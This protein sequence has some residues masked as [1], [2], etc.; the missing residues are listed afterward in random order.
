MSLL[1]ELDQQ[2]KA[3]ESELQQDESEVET[4]DH[5]ELEPIPPLPPE[6]R[7]PPG[8]L[9]AATRRKEQ[10]LSKKQVEC[11]ICSQVFEGKDAF[12][13]HTRTLKHRQ[14][15]ILKAGAFYEAANHQANFCR[16]CNLRF[17]DI[18]DLLNHRSTQAH[19]AAKEKLT[20]ASFCSVCNK[21]FTSPLQLRGHIEGKAHIDKVE[22]KTG[23]RISNNN[24]DHYSKKQKLSKT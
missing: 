9:I 6:Q 8:S 13:K 16:A 15:S 4:S 23:F 3:L 21:Q 24:H 14:N 18:N 22:L 17:D 1:N 7:V 20:R 19:R 10:L 11:K 2:I 5:D 12:R